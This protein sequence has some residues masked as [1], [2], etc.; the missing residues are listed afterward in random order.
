M[1]YDSSE[2]KNLEAGLKLSWMQQQLHTQNI[3]N[4]E[5]PG[6]KAKN[7]VFHKILS[8]K[9]NNTLSNKI[10][11]SVKQDETLSSRNDGNNVDIEKESLALYKSYV[12]Y[13]ALLNKVNEKFDQ[14]SYVLNSD[15]K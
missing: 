14:Y 7:L 1:F 10:S 6:Y 4:I 8:D 3:A 13:T 12:Q 9:T 11:A 5:T 15:F 2:F